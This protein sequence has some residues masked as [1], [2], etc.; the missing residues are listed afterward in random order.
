M[1]TKLTALMTALAVLGTSATAQAGR[2]DRDDGIEYADVIDTRP[3]YRDVRVTVPREE[4]SQERVVYDDGYRGGRNNDAVGA[5]LGAVV[6]GV[7]GNR[8]GQLL[9]ASCDSNWALDNGGHVGLGD[10]L[11]AILNGHGATSKDD[12][13]VG[14]L[15]SLTS[16]NRDADVASALDL[17]GHSLATNGHRLQVCVV[18]IGQSHGSTSS[19]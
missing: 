7:V 8:F 16:R 9:S 3:V 15:A 18:T 6:G 19:V 10:I 17:E 11:D 13:D 14:S 5:V 1:N 4:C 2:H 12:H